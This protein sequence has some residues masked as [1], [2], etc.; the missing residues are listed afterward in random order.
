MVEIYHTKK[1][2]RNEVEKVVLYKMGLYFTGFLY[3]YSWV[4]TVAYLFVSNQIVTCTIYA[5]NETV[6][7]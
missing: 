3:I 6:Q 2:D 7:L 4:L 5:L 1:G